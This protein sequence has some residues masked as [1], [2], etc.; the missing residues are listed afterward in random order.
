MANNTF[1]SDWREQ[2]CYVVAVSKPL[3]PYV[4]GLLK[5]LE[6][7][8]FWASEE[9]FQAGYQSTLEL[10]ACL[11]A[12][13]LQDFIEGQNR[14]YRLLDTALLGGEY[15]VTSEDPLIITPDIPLV[16][17]LPLDDNGA[18]VPLQNRLIQLVDNTFNGTETPLYDYSPSI[19]A[20]LQAV[21]DA[22]AEGTDLT[23]VLTQLEGIAALLA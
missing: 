2:P 3:A 18:L 16:P 22:L 13:C 21:I 1:P 14:L 7:R 12:T 19:K 23:D 11:M 9:D 15:A 6:K 17:S 4:G 20:Q 5:I 8:G 10:E